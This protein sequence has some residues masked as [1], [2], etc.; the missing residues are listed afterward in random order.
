MLHHI[1][2]TVRT[3]L[4]AAA[5]AG[6]VLAAPGSALASPAH[7]ASFAGQHQ[8]RV[9]LGSRS[10]DRKHHRH[11]DPNAHLTQ[12]D[13]FSDVPGLAA[14]TDPSV[15]NPWGLA[16]LPTSTMWV[17]DQGTDSSTAYALAPGATS[18]TASTI[19][20]TF[21]DSKTGPTGQVANPGSGFVLDD[22]KPAQFIFDTLDGRIEAW[23][24]ADGATGTADT[25]ATVAGAGYT[26]LAV[27]PTRHGDEL[28]A[29][30]FATGTVDV[31]D[32]DFQQVTL[33]PWQFHDPRLPQGYLAFNTQVLHGHVFVTYDTVDPS[34]A[35]GAGPEGLGLGVG[36]VDE[37]TTSGRLVA[38]IAAG[39]RLD[40]PW[41]LAI[42]PR[43][44]GRAAGSLLV[45]N[46]GDGRINIF[47]K[48]GRHFA[49]HATG[50]VL[51]SS[52]GKPFAEPGLWS[53]TPGT[54]DTTGGRGALWFSAGISDPQGG[55]REH[56]GLIGVL[57][58]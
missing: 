49:R 35:T 28:F 24:S 6:V 51:N 58:P 54:S 18:G 9:T 40:A 2:P 39:G 42:A 57:R 11:L 7:Q 55:P 13:L 4:V 21:P 56:D 33:Q 3:A 38:R 29:A 8:H 16:A 53:L 45:G 17:S 50:Q 23:D 12:V 43:S 15:V 31:F 37:Y 14:K 10:H 36:V 1:R 5:T 22:G 25:M 47:A 48:E 27:G 20:V 52:T 32:S 34:P 41:G 46:F 30:N 19:H 44:W 26:G